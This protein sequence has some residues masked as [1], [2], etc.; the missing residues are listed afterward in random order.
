MRQIAV[1]ALGRD[2]PVL[3]FGCASIGSRTSPGAALRALSLA[4]DLGVRWFDVAPPYGDGRAE[5]ILGEFL[6]GRR[7]QAIICTKVGLEPPTVSRVKQWARPLAR[8]VV[9]GFPG[10]RARISAARPSGQRALL[11]EVA[12]QSVKRSLERL[13]VDHIDILAWHDPPLAEANDPAARDL[14]AG[15]VASGQARAISVTGEPETV[16]AALA[17]D[18]RIG[19]GQVGNSPFRRAHDVL[20]GL[21]AQEGERQLVTHSIFS[22]DALA[23]AQQM[24]WLDDSQ[25]RAIMEE[26][27]LVTAGDLLMDYALSVQRTGIV[28]ASMVSERNV[29]RNV[30]LASLPPSS[31]LVERVDHLVT[32][33]T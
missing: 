7:D 8:R 26:R 19:F 4:W 25:L 16:A 9:A 24:G 28:I 10:L 14:L 18:R 11:T 23:C 30:E 27:G 6:R 2:S 17:A 33:A 21:L 32:T 22:G 13:R 5:A 20:A 3:A 15:F 29:R 31:K 1:P 12:A